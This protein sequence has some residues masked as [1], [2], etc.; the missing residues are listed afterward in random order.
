MLF[1]QSLLIMIKE[2]ICHMNV[3]FL[4]VVG[5]FRAGMG[6]QAMFGSDLTGEGRVLWMNVVRLER[7]RE[8]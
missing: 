8:V 7:G 2:A 6:L 3:A 1:F 5:L 4:G